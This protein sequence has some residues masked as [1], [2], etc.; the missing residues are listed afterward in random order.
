MLF[1]WLLMHFPY[2]LE[3]LMAYGWSED[4]RPLEWTAGSVREC[5]RRKGPGVFGPLTPCLF[6]FPL[7]LKRIIM[8][9]C[10]RQAGF[11]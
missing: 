2:S 10:G 6:P 1:P 5:R 7:A 4:R 3:R 11:T 8:V 9:E